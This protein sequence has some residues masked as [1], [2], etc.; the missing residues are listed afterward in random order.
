MKTTI[1]IADDLAATLKKRT[2][3]EGISMRAAVHEALR[4][5]L[6]SQPQ[7]APPESISKEIGL[8]SGEGLSREAS[9]LSW[10]ELRSLSYDR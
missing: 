9:A 7:P 10:T 6:K 2:A 1:D 8:V 5:W 4:L 3:S